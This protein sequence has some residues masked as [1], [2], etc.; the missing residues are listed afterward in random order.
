MGRRPSPLVRRSLAVTV[1]LASA[2]ASHAAAAWAGRATVPAV[3]GRPAILVASRAPESA[4]A[5]DAERRIHAL[6]HLARA[7]SRP[8]MPARSLLVAVVSGLT[9]RAHPGRGRVLG[10]MPSRS[11]YYGVRLVA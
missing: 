6:A 7:S 10:P 9:V 11:K 2:V 1:I 5:T 8:A 3:S 4:A